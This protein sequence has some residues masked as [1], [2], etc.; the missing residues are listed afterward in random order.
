MNN[1]STGMADLLLTHFV[2]EKAVEMTPVCANVCW[3]T[4]GKRKGKRKVFTFLAWRRKMGSRGLQ[5]SSDGFCTKNL[6]LLLFLD[7]RM[8]I[9]LLCCFFILPESATFS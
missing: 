5:C 7:V 4:A 8:K 6:D 1:S 2:S 3:Q 9:R